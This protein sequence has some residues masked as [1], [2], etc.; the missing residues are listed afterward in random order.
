MRRNAEKSRRE[1]EGIIKKMERIW[2]EE[3]IASGKVEEV[4]T[5]GEIGFDGGED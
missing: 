4:E 1:V 3:R 2:K 5:R